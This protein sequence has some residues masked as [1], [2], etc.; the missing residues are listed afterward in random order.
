MKEDDFLNWVKTDENGCWVWQRSKHKQGYGAAQFRGKYELGHRIAWKIY[1]GE[2][3]KG[4]MVCHKCD[5]TSCC[6]PEHL[7]LG[8]Q[9]DNVSDAI[10][11]G[12]FEDRKQSKRRN[13]LNWEQVQEIKALKLQGVSWKYLKDK[14]QVSQTCIAKILRGDSW[15]INWTEQEQ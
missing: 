9:K 3:P 14:F 13:K 5:I 8:T 15:K 7:F 12:K 11:K 4:M 10:S 1:R 6:N 2:I